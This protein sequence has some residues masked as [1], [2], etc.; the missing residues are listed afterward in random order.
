MRLQKWNLDRNLSNPSNVTVATPYI[1]ITRNIETS[2]RLF[3]KNEQNQFCPK[4]ARTMRKVVLVVE[5]LMHDCDFRV[6][7]R[8][9]YIKSIHK[10]RKASAANEL[11]ILLLYV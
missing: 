1:V 10:A 9:A 4:I 8:N 3:S 2:N 11:Q 6:N 5:K 7:S